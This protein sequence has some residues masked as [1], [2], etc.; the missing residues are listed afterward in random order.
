MSILK[1]RFSIRLILLVLFMGFSTFI[2]LEGYKRLQ[3]Y[4]KLN[5]MHL[6]IGYESIAHSEQNL[7]SYFIKDILTMPEFKNLFTTLNEKNL[8]EKRKTLYRL[9]KKRYEFLKEG[10]VLQLHFHLPSGKSFLRFHVSQQYGDDL[11]TIRPTV[12][13][14]IETKSL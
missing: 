5:S 3:A 13:E 11:L 4:Y 8:D 2:T 9:F 6:Q 12:K 10:G 1:N 7:V 14:V